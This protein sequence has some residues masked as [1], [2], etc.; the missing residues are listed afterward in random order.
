MAQTEQAEGEYPDAID[1]A[2]TIE[3]TQT[4]EIETMKE[5]L[6]S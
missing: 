3:E 5:L 6:A 2:E 1:L 4:T